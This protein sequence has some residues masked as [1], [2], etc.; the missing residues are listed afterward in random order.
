MVVAAGGGWVVAG[1]I[2]LGMLEHAV[3]L[4]PQAAIAMAC[5]MT[6]TPADAAHDRVRVEARRCRRTAD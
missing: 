4:N 1:C 5:F 2:Q 6:R 3:R